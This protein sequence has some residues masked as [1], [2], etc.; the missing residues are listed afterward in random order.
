MSGHFKRIDFVQRNDCYTLFE[1]SML[2]KILA[3]S[4]V[5]YDNVVKFSTSCDLKRCRLVVVI[6]TEVN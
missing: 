2:Q 5:L 4:F 3:H 6:R 1:L